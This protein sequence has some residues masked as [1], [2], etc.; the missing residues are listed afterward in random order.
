MS[1]RARYQ[2]IL[3]IAWPV[4]GGLLGLLALFFS[5][6]VTPL[7]F[8]WALAIQWQAARVRCAKCGSQVGLGEYN[9][10]GFRFRWWKALPGPTCEQCGQDLRTE[11]E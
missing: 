10:G 6:Y 2:A 4:G 3:W 8:A 7:L 5:A 11:D 9:V 1:P